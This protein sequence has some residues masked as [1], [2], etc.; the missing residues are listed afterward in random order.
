MR[1]DEKTKKSADE[2]TIFE[3]QNIK[4]QGEEKFEVIYNESGNNNIKLIANNNIKNETDEED[5]SKKTLKF[6]EKRKENHSALSMSSTFR[7]IPLR[8]L[9]EMRSKKKIMSNINNN[10]NKEKVAYS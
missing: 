9:N 10:N 7:V 6:Q 3:Q 8:K 2:T 1:H 4:N 5:Y